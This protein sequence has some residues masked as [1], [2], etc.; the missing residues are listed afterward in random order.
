MSC[1]SFVRRFISTL[2][3]NQVFTTR[4]CLNLGTRACVDKALQKLVKTGFILRQLTGGVFVR[5]FG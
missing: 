2:P 5:R 4:E 3:A 1:P